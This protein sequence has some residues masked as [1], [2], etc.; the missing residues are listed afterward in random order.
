MQRPEKPPADEAFGT[1]DW[2]DPSELPL[3]E[4]RDVFLNLSKALRAYQLYDPNNPVYKRFVSSLRESIVR[5]WPTVERLQFLVEEDRFTWMGEEV[6]RNDNRSDSLAFMFYRDGIRDL[7]LEPGVEGPEIEG[8]LD[9]LHRARNARGG[10]DLVTLLWDLD[11]KAFTYS[12]VEAGEGG[13]GM[14][15]SG[16][17]EPAAL[18]VGGVLQSELPSGEREEPAE[19]EEGGSADSS[20]PPR[21]A[22]V[23]T[24]DF[25]PTLYALDEHERRYLLDELRVEMDR[26]LRRDVLNALF[27]RLEEPDRPDRQREILEILRNLVPS[28]LSRGALAPTATVVEEINAA[29]IRE[30]LLDDECQALAE[31]LLEDLSAPEAVRELISALEDGTVAPDAAELGALLRC[32]RA[33]SLNS[34]LKGAE[35]SRDDAVKSLL[36]EAIQEIAQGNP[37]VVV[38]L[39]ESDDIA[40]ASGAVRLVGRMKLGEAGPSLVRLL[41]QGS[42]QVRKVI[43]ETAMEVP[44]SVL[45]TALTKLLRDED[46]ELR[47][48]AARVLGDMSFAPAAADFR[49]VLE[50]K[51]FREADV[52]EKVAFFEAYGM[53]AGQDAVAFLEGIL[54]GKGFLG[55][56]E[57]AELRAGAALA[58]GKIG[59]DRAGRALDK[60]A[61]DDDPVVRTA[62]RRA[63][64]GA[65]GNVE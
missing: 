15:L 57:P 53:L 38:G 14:E 4:V 5:L 58:L 16:L 7:T 6:Y 25:N 3:E 39:L 11:L 44:S 56:K 35:E 9:A 59:G 32:L 17:G 13:E 43:V 54:N 23:S 21:P 50:D 36:R 42:R 62:V 61:K 1:L 60:A 34:L 40:V 49:G 2:A 47:V 22:T 41:E 30:G 8:L 55:R 19:G 65:E 63:R 37:G 24:E 33:G 28:L 48:A 18:N 51:E 46:R 64:K 26:D 31:Q 45:A 10:E 27:D 20:A 52:T 12:A 29:R